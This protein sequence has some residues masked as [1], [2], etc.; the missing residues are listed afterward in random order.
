MSDQLFEILLHEI[1]ANTNTHTVAQNLSKLLGVSSKQLEM[2]LVKIK[3]SNGNPE[4]LITGLSKEKAE[5]FQNIL[6][7]LGLKTTI[8]LGMSMVTMKKTVKVDAFKC[9]ACGLKQETKAGD[10]FQTCTDCGVVKQKYEEVQGLKKYEEGVIKHNR[11]LER[12][13]KQFSKKTTQ[14]KHKKQLDRSIKAKSK[15]GKKQIVLASLVLGSI[16]IGISAYFMLNTSTINSEPVEHQT[17]RNNTPAAKPSS[18]AIAKVLA[19]QALIPSSNEQFDKSQNPYDKFSNPEMPKISM[20]EGAN[21]INK[22]LETSKLKLPDSDK[23]A[24]EEISQIYQ[25]AESKPDHKFDY[26]AVKRIANT[27]DDEETKNSVKQQLNLE[28]IKHGYQSFDN[29][30]IT[31]TIRKGEDAQVVKLSNELI[32][33]FIESKQYKKAVKTTDQIKDK[34]LKAIALNKIL[35][36]QAGTSIE[37]AKETNSIIRITGESE[38]DTSKKILITATYAQGIILIDDKKIGEKI[39]NNVS[40]SVNRIKKPVNKIMTLIQLSEDQR[41]GLSFDF[42]NMFLT[43]AR[44]KLETEKLSLV[45]QDKLYQ[46]LGIQYAKL[47]DLTQANEVI[48][49]ISNTKD[50][51]TAIKE[52]TKIEASLM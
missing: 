20:A 22:L 24:L 52:I 23:A 47:L 16:A 51:I 13:E 12:R 18:A 38:R 11:E 30:G 29:L 27:I 21:K 50:K 1:E 19:K 5:K 37:K 15:T 10:K 9:P 2:Q 14:E 46:L 7:Q 43:D 32:D 36:F 39:L 17:E 6:N 33:T 41:E 45:E 25:T 40:S 26:S 49:K 31:P 44:E 42:S 48:E 28:I 34:Y 4:A 3:L 35:R 8:K